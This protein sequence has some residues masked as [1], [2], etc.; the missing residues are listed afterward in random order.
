MIIKKII[1][2]ITH[3]TNLSIH[4]A[5]WLLEHICNKTKV[6]LLGIETL[7]KQE[8]Q[9]LDATLEQITKHHKPLAYIIGSVPFLDLTIKV[10]PPMLIPRHETEEW[11]DLLIKRLE[12]H[13]HEIHS[14]LDIGTG[15]GCIAIA[16]AKAFPKAHIVALDINPK[17]LNLAQDNATSNNIQNVTFLQSDLFGNIPT[18]H[19]FDLIISNPPYIDPAL[20]STLLPEVTNWEDHGALFAPQKGIEIIEK[21][22]EKASCFLHNSTTLPTQLVLEIDYTQKDTVLDRALAHGWTVQ[23][24]QDSF[25]KWRTIYCKKT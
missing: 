6:Q 10:Q 14:I 19:R 7:T 23:P 5:W 3:D 4:E 17:A 16:I 2:K 8:Q 12:P 20:Q 18:N 11:V 15:S 22:L 25:G 21:I 13:K 9:L 24:Y 1:A